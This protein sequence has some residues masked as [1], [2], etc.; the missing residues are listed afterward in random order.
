MAEVR[1]IKALLYT[2]K[3]GR[4]EDNVC[5][6]YDIISGEERERLIKRSP[7][8]LVNL[9]LPVD[10]FPD[11]CDRYDEAG[12]KLSEWIQTGILGRDSKEGMFV[13]R[14]KFSVKGRE[15]TVTG[16]ICLVKL[17]DFSE[18]IV[19]PHEETLS[20]AKT[21]RFNLMNAT[22][23]NFSSVYS[24]YL[25]PAGT[26]KRVLLKAVESKPEKE[27]T[28]E[29]G[30][31]HLLW[32][33]E[34]ENE[35]DTLIRAFSDKQLFIA[36]GHHRYETALNFKKHLENQ[37]KL[38]GTTADCMMMTL[39]DMD[40]EGLVIF[41]THRL[42]TGLD[43]DKQELLEK[44]SGYFDIQEYPD[45]SKAGEILEKFRNK[46]VFA[47]YDGGEGF[48][49]LSAKP[50]V[51][52]MVFESRSKAYSSLDV[53]VLH[54]L[55]LENGLGIDKQ[56]M[57]NQI[58]LRYTRSSEEAVERVRKGECSLAFI[59][60]PTQINEIKDVS[61]AGDKMPQ[62]STYFYPKLKTGLVMNQLNQRG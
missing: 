12:K 54:S 59:I 61:L 2:E 9:E 34:D 45:V 35:L 57:A 24:L 50:Q 26:I 56:N 48:T 17:Y 28:D 25:D 4:L 62:K 41:P 40:D 20:K 49:L 21:D 8:N 58:N 55:I 13:Y 18:K 15:Y 51:D 52:D 42:V 22:Y 11:S 30:V 10:T 37:K 43:I 53:T 7:Y 31:T 16:L 47:M 27:F 19:L 5:P 29:E 38:S 36:D 6:P 3:A 60:N 23:C 32:K 46:H 14:E 1:K 39:V 44:I 33:I